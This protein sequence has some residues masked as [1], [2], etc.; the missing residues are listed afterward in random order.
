MIKLFETYM[1]SAPPAKWK[2][3][4]REAAKMAFNVKYMFREEVRIARDRFRD[5]LALTPGPG[6]DMYAALAEAAFGDYGEGGIVD[7]E[8]LASSNFLTDPQ[9]LLDVVRA[10]IGRSEPKMKLIREITLAWMEVK[11]EDGFP[12]CV[13]AM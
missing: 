12:P 7:P 13:T 9:E 8:V 3:L 5:N 4:F 11:V 10:Q 1:A 6:R 2:E